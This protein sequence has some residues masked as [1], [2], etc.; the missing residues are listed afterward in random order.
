M[1]HASEGESNHEKETKRCTKKLLFCL[2][3]EGTC[4]SE[5]EKGNDQILGSSA[6][7]LKGPIDMKVKKLTAGRS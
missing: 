1:L 5:D 2:A 7:S 6:P 3:G 4:F